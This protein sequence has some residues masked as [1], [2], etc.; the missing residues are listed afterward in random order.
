MSY[1][2]SKPQQAIDVLNKA[3]NLFL[4]ANIFTETEQAQKA[5]EFINQRL[6]IVEERLNLDKNNLTQFRSRNNTLNV[7]KEISSII[8]TIE[9][10]EVSIYD[11]NVE[12][13]EAKKTFTASNPILENLIERK[14]LLESRKNE[15]EL[16]IKDLPLE[17]QEYIDLFR[18]LETTSN[19]VKE[20]EE[21]KLEYSIKEASTLG[22]IRIVDEGY[23]VGIVSPKYSSVL[24]TTALGFIFILVFALLRG[25]FFIP[26]FNPA[27]VKENLPDSN[28]VG[29]LP[30]ETDGDTESGKAAAEGLLVNVDFLLEQK[31]IISN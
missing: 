9:S 21:K 5:I 25:M 10:L 6:K 12:I 29:V 3:N 15:I 4:N 17:Q 26:I 11:L 13:T 20:L 19:I 8:E 7:E 22:N 23:I 16:Q 28:L 27:E 2:S 18:K 1:T 14:A 24:Y 30:Y 31:I